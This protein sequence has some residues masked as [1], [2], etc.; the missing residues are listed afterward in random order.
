MKWDPRFYIPSE[1]RR[2]EDFFALK[3]PPASAGFELA[4]LGTKGQRA[5]PQTTEA[6][7]H[8]LSFLFI[9]SSPISLAPSSICT[10]ASFSHPVLLPIVYI[11]CIHQ[12]QPQTPV[13]KCTIAKA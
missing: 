4:N 9:Y 2:T 5:N 12:T 7:Y 11:I 1:G 3:N 6:A 13:T 10:T 8:V